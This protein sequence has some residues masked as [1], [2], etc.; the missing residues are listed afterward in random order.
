MHSNSLNPIRTTRRAMLGGG[1]A[2]LAGAAMLAGAPAALALSPDDAKSLVS[3]TVDEVLALA[4]ANGTPEAK[5]PQLRR[6]MEAHATMPEIARASAGIA[7]RQMSADQQARFVDAFTDYV[8][9][10]YARRFQEYSGQRI[11][12]GQVRDAG[13]KGVLVQTSV[14]GGGAPILVEWLVS[15]RGGRPAINDI[16]IEGVS[17]VLTQR[18]EIAGMLTARG[19]DVEKLISALQSA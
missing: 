9:K 14:I 3:R 16:V 4:Q 17:L 12:V 6:I 11:A 5:A 19:N 18:E 8:A 7:W 15:D 10:I 2:L 13:K 1:V